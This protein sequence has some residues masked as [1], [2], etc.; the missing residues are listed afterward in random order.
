MELHGNTFKKGND[1]MAMAPLLPTPT[2]N[3]KHC[4][5]HNPPVDIH[6]LHLVAQ[7][8][9]HLK[10]VR[11]LPDPRPPATC[12]ATPGR[13]SWPPRAAS[14]LHSHNRAAG[15]AHLRRTPDRDPSRN[16]AKLRGR[17][18]GIRSPRAPTAAPSRSCQP[19]VALKATLAREA[20]HRGPRPA[21]SPAPPTHTHQ[22]PPLE[23]RRYSSRR[24]REKTTP[25]PP[26]LCGL[27]PRR[28]VAAARW[29]R[30][31]EGADRS[32]AHGPTEPFL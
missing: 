26:T 2:Q 14:R 12:A 17:R 23:I 3:P 8:P 18:P 21:P 30:K 11:D 27:C 19:R 9:P 6:R 28:P 7:Q 13:L 16:T 22:P 24:A 20:R 10:N 4:T 29:G 15:A 25:P 5:A 32:G 1:T 31:R